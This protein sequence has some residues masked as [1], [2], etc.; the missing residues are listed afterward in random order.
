M[1]FVQRQLVRLVMR[2]VS[3]PKLTL[4]V[5]ALALVAS[6][7]GAWT[8]LGMSADQEELMTPKL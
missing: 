6:V 7:V 8:G 5:C 1:G 2:A 4:A 3:F